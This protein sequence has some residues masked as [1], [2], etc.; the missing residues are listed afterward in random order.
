M[1]LSAQSTITVTALGNGVSTQ[2]TIG[3]PFQLNAQVEVWLQNEG[4]TPFTRTQLAYGTNPAQYQIGTGTLGA[5]GD[6]DPGATVFLGQPLGSSQRLII[7]RVTPRAQTVQYRTTH[8]FP[9][10]NHEA[11]MDRIVQIVQEL[12]ARTLPSVAPMD[13][14]AAALTDGLIIKFRNGVWTTEQGT[15]ENLEDVDFIRPL[16]D[17]DLLAYKLGTGKWQPIRQSELPGGTGGSG[18]PIGN[19]L[20][21]FFGAAGGISGLLPTDLPVDAFDKMES[22]LELLA[23]A[24]PLNLSTKTL[25]V[26]AP[27]TSKEAGTGTSIANCTDDTTPDVSA[28]SF[29]DGNVGTLTATIDGSAAGSIVL[30]TG[31]ETGVTD[32]A[33]TV[34]TDNDPYVGQAGKSGFWRQIS[35]TITPTSPLSLGAHPFTMS[36][37]STGTASGVTVTVDDPGVVTFGTKSASSTGSSNYISGVPGVASGQ[38]ITTSFQVVNAVRTHYNSTHVGNASSP[39]TNSVDAN[40]GSVPANGDTLTLTPSLT[41]AAS[42]Y[43]EGITVTFTGYNSKGTA[44]TTTQTTAIRVDT[45]SN[46]TG[47]LKSGQGQYPAIGSG[48]SQFGDAFVAA[49]SLATSGNEELQLLNGTYRY[50]SGNYSSNYPVGPD[51]S[52]VPAGSYSNYRWLTVSLGSISALSNKTINING[53]VNL[54]GSTL[55]SGLLMYVKVVGA[56]PTSGWVDANAAYPGVGN[57]T[58]DGDGALVVGSSSTSTR[59]VTFGSAPKTGTVYVRIGIPSGSTKQF[60]G[61]S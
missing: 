15:L 12:E 42:K 29:R 24:P 41:I 37:S 34:T 52:S 10:A 3:F 40:P 57:P 61:V 23:P 6:D 54:G 36:H 7:K 4:V 55:I 1:T 46:E 48:A 53:G 20:D 49:T 59:V 14:D 26:T 5:G 18:G 2:Y 50:P 60:S 51:Y 16:E 38:A 47:R 58:N 8:A 9:F 35:A 32:T 25:A 13:I 21:G 39:Q 28:T 44:Y 31:D 30:T 43:S 11:Q 22:I 56:T 19:P 45:V 33:L 17:G 27:Y